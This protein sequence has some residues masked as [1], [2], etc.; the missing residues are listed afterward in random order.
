MDLKLYP[1][2]NSSSNT[3]LK[4]SDCL[5]LTQDKLKSRLITLE[6]GI[7]YEHTSSISVNLTAS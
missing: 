5:L 2:I 1:D 3:L 7:T 4:Q 6:V